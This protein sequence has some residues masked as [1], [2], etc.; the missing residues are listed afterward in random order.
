LNLRPQGY[1][2]CELPLLHPASKCR[3]YT[4]F[5]GM[6]QEDAREIRA[7]CFQLWPCGEEVDGGQSQRGEARNGLDMLGI[8]SLNR[9][10]NLKDLGIEPS[11]LIGIGCIMRWPSE[12]ILPNRPTPA[13]FTAVNTA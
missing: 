11:G 9:I 1:E 5:E 2:P 10:P 12:L 6:S 7:A 4:R 8:T 3:N 13:R